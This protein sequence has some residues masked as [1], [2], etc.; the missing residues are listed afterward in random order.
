MHARNLTLKP[1]S[2]AATTVDTL[3]SFEKSHKHFRTVLK[4]STSAEQNCYIFQLRCL[5]VISVPG[6]DRVARVMHA[7]IPEAKKLSRRNGWWDK[8]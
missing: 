7:S 5:E 4:S 8:L 6:F 1:L 3:I 2:K